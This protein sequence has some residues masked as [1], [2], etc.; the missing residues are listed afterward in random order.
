MSLSSGGLLTVRVRQSHDWSDGTRPGVRVTI[1][2]TGTG[3][4]WEVRRRL[5][6]AFFTSNKENGTGL[7]MWVTSQVVDRNQGVLHVWSTNHPGSSG[8]VF[9]LFLPVK[10]S[11]QRLK[12]WD[13]TTV[14]M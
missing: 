14:L 10:L 3:M 12:T 7:G 13:G 11:S 5:Y 4:T 1:A 8:T 2:D 6:E 9:S